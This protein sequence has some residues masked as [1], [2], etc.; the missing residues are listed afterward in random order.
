MY[1]QLLCCGFMSAGESHRWNLAMQ[2]LPWMANAVAGFS[3]SLQQRNHD[4]SIEVTMAIVPYYSFVKLAPCCWRQV[5]TNSSNK[6]QRE[7]HPGLFYLQKPSWLS[8][9]SVLLLHLHTSTCQESSNSGLSGD[10]CLTCQLVACEITRAEQS[11]FLILIQLKCV[12]FLKGQG[13]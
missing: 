8:W 12:L 11:S 13:T 10:V 4:G 5:R 2:L 1:V 6:S 3:A 7:R 9:Q